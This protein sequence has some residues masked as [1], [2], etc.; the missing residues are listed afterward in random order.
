MFEFIAGFLAARV[1]NKFTIS[2]GE[3]SEPD[4]L[5][6]KFNRGQIVSQ[7]EMNR[8]EYLSEQESMKGNTL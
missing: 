4:Q 6:A 1:L 7:R 3:P 2:L 5:I 8:M